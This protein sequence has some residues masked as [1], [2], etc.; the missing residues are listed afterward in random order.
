[1]KRGQYRYSFTPLHIGN[2]SDAKDGEYLC[3]PITGLPGM[4][5]SNGDVISSGLLNRLSAHKDRLNTKLAFNGM[6]TSSIYQLE[7]DTNTTGT[8][9]A[10]FNNNLLDGDVEITVSN[11]RFMLSFDM[12][13]LEKGD[14][15]IMIFSQYDPVL[16]ITYEMSGSGTTS[17]YTSHISNISESPIVLDGT[18][19]TIK[20]IVMKNDGYVPATIKCILYSILIAF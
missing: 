6:A 17:I 3:D 9:E 1:M 12:D 14:D 10:V 4:K 18:D 2:H 20:S 7:F 15:N 5:T 13:V 8:R 19:F 11:G 16:D